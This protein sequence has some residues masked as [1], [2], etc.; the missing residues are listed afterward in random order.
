MNEYI[1]IIIIIFSFSLSLFLILCASIRILYTTGLIPPFSFSFFFLACLLK[2][3]TFTHLHITSYVF[4]CVCAI[5]PG[6]SMI[7]SI[8][9]F[10]SLPSFFPMLLFCLPPPSLRPSLFCYRPSS[11]VFLYPTFSSFIFHLSPP[12][13]FSIP[14][15]HTKKKLKLLVYVKLGNDFFERIGFDVVTVYGDRRRPFF[16]IGITT[17][18]INSNSNNNKND[19]DSGRRGRG[20][21]EFESWSES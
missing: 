19:S 2:K 8:I 21:Y 18:N 7:S 12:S 5:C 20:G 1:I 11:I 9:N 4:P 6:P 3:I 13:N 10:F 14:P 16:N 17:T 15:P